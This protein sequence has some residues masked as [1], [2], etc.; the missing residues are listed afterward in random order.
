M[1][2]YVQEEYIDATQH[3]YCGNSDVY[4]TGHDTIGT[5]Y[6]A[7][8]REWGRC[9]GKVYLD[10]SCPEQGE[11]AQAIGWVFVRRVRY[12]DSRKTYLRK[13]WAT[14]HTR[15]PVKSTQYHYEGV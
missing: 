13:V 8:R 10:R 9:I 15:P 2:L 6:R 5:L 1:S 3:A 14:V 7:L 4:E 11:Y 12:E